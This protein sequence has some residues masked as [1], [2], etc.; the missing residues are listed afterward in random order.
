MFLNVSCNE[1]FSYNIE[2]FDSFEFLGSKLKEIIPECK[3]ICVVSDDNVWKLYG[4]EIEKINFDDCYLTKFIINPGEQSKSLDNVEKLLSFLLDEN[5]SRKDCVLALGGGVV[6]DFA[7]FAASLYKRG[8]NTFYVPTTLLAMADASSG[9]KTAVDFNG[10][11]NVVGSFKMPSYIYINLNTLKTL[12]AREYFAGFA[13]I[14]KAGLIADSKF[15]MWLIDNMYE[16]CEMDEKA[17]EEML[18]QSI[19]IKKSIVERDPYE[20]GDRALLNLGHT[21]GHAIESFF[22]GE[23][24]HGEA[25]SMGIVG[26]AF[27]SWKMNLIEMEDYYEIRDM[28]VPF[29]LPIS[30]EA[31]DTSEIMDILYKD[32]KNTK[33]CINMVLLKK[34]GKAVLVENISPDLIKQAISELNF[35]EKEY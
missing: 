10:I 8:L 12:P 27:I 18:S 33:D 25:I 19:N 4:K 14:M 28:F 3:K 34:I 2:S 21:I 1:N 26:S 5:F 22:K 20:K 30:F 23:Y 11:K 6:S 16:I 9:G 17:L 32:K 13:E 7:G 24:L 29:N 35:S 15:Y 31:S